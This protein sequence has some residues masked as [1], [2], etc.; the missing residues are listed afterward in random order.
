M[1]VFGDFHY[2]N[3]VACERDEFRG[4]GFVKPVMLE[5]LKDADNEGVTLALMAEPQALPNG[6]SLNDLVSWYERFGFVD[7]TD[8]IAPGIDMRREP[9]PQG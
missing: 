1:E 2:V 7:A 9:L 6:L 3:W 4:Q 5:M 8:G